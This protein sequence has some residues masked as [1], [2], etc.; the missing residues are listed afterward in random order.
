MSHAPAD[1]LERRHAAIRGVLPTQALDALIVTSLPNVLYLT[2][3]TGTAG[4]VVLMTDRLLFVTDSRYVTAVE[5]MRG[6]PYGCPGLE[7]VVV[8]GS[9]DA[10]I[11]RTLASLPAQRIGFEAGHLTVSRHAWLVEALAGLSQTPKELVATE[12]IVERARVRK[13]EYEIA[14]LREAARRLSSVTQR[15]LAGIR[16][17]Q[18]ERDVAFAIDSRVREGGFSRS[19]FET[20][21]AA[22]PNAALPHARP[23]ER[24]LTEGDLVVLD[25]G[26]VYDSYCVDLTR[27]VSIGRA[28]EQARTVHAAVRE[29]HDRAIAAVG[30]GRSRFDIDAAARDVL[31]GQGLG[32]A[33]GHGTGHGLGI[34]VHEEPRIV[35]RRPD[36]DTRDE[37]VQPGM[38]FTIEPGAYLPDWGGVR[39]EDD[40]LVTTDGVEVLTDVTTELLEL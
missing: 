39:I 21:V 13:D 5:S 33:F 2:N 32:E 8:E 16:A 15:V 19:A 14:T 24:K 25:F 11:V 37:A 31:T 12:G 40:V 29:A 38:V 4:V 35:R 1:L 26:G 30:P 9:Y 20:I 6:L 28:G 17:G 7:L 34:E 23:G 36:V 27:T 22:G 3:F 10:M 18:T